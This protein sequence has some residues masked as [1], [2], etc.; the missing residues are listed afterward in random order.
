MSGRKTKQTI[1]LIALR[2]CV[3][4]GVAGAVQCADCVKVERVT[5]QLSIHNRSWHRYS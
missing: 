1:I 4:G 3:G 2:A 5:C